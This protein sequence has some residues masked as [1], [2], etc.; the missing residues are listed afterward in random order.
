MK[1]I[2]IIL[3][4]SLLVY[5][6]V[7]ADYT[8]NIND[9]LKIYS[10]DKKIWDIIKKS[11]YGEEIKKELILK[12]TKILWKTEDEIYKI[13][14]L[15]KIRL[16][17]FKEYALIKVYRYLKYWDNIISKNQTVKVLENKYIKVISTA[18]N[19]FINSDSVY[20]DYG[21]WN[22]WKMIEFFDIKPES[23]TIDFINNNFLEAEFIWKCKATLSPEKAISFTNNQTY[24]ISAYWDYIS[25]ELY[26][27]IFPCWKYWENRSI[28]YFERLSD[29][30]LIYI[31]AWQDFNW[32][33]FGSIEL[34]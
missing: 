21:D 9:D 19:I 2:L 1:K 5:P 25:D 28:T 6:K 18:P 29:D 34:K 31:N 23:D 15:R 4:L 16:E 13:W 32:L 20:L 30:L 8:I 10:F 11:K 17:S 7:S 27:E 26:Y 33:D 3:V 14:N 22:K 12:I 24:H